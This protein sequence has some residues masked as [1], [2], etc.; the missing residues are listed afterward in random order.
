MQSPL[1]PPFF[2]SVNYHP[3]LPLSIRPCVDPS[4]HPSIL[5]PSRCNNRTQCVVVAGVDVF[6]DPCPGTYKYLEIQYE[7][8]PYSEYTSVLNTHLYC[9]IINT[10]THTHVFHI[11]IKFLLLSNYVLGG[12]CTGLVGGGADGWGGSVFLLG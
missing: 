11:Q 8:V 6:P 7:C 4:I 5:S 10:H 9:N 12:R 2:L 1:F 3:S